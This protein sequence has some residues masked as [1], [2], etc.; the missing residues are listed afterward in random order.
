MNSIRQA[1]EIGVERTDNDAWVG[2]MEKGLVGKRS[3]VECQQGTPSLA[4]H[5]EN[6]VV[7]APTIEASG[8]FQTRDVVTQAPELKHDGTWESI[9]DEQSGHTLSRLALLD[10]TI[11]FIPMCPN[12]DPGIGQILGLK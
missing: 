2:E 3:V 9:V 8:F 7:A 12:V 1:D 6:F 4:R 10:L 5:G 11:D